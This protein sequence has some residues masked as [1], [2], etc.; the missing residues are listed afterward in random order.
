MG[1]SVGPSL[2]NKPGNNIILFNKIYKNIE[3]SSWGHKFI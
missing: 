3:L 1:P 2:G